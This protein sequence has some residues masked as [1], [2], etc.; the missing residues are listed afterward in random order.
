MIIEII[1]EEIQNENLQ[2]WFFKTSDGTLIHLN[3]ILDE[4]IIEVD[5]FDD[6]KKYVSVVYSDWDSRELRAIVDSVGNVVYK[7]IQS[8]E[9]YIS[10]YELFII[11]LNSEYI[12][13]ESVTYFGLQTDTIYYNVINSNGKM[14]I[15]FNTDYISF[16][17][18]RFCVNKEYY[19]IE[20]LMKRR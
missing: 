5:F 15:G 11:E 3:P 20:E 8:I 18:E 12:N 4:D 13:A 14:L 6:D 2:K 16:E 19:T 7:G 10:E 1:S 9:Q 17:E